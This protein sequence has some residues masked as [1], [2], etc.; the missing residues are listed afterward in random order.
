VA[1]L[2]NDEHQARKTKA[3]LCLKKEKPKPAKI[4]EN[5]SLLTLKQISSRVDLSEIYWAT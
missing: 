3:Y 5:C 1:K 2:F 4:F